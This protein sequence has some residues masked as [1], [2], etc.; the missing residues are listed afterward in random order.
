MNNSYSSVLKLI[1]PP[2]MM[3]LLDG[4]R[5]YVCSYRILVKT[6]S[7]DEKDVDSARPKQ[8]KIAKNSQRLTGHAKATIATA[9]VNACTLILAGIRLAFVD[10]C[11]ATRTTEPG[12]AIAAIRSRD[13]DTD[14]FVL[15]RRS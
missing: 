8:E 13:V 5:K 12:G 15:T 14:T 1:E 3:S 2:T 7:R 11:F 10:V 9:L 6:D 4:L